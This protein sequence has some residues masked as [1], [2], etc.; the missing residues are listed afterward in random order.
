ME[1]R[2]GW[3][4]CAWRWGSAGFRSDERSRRRWNTS[5]CS[6]STLLMTYSHLLVI[7]AHPSFWTSKQR[8]FAQGFENGWT[9]QVSDCSNLLKVTSL[10]RHVFAKNPLILAT[11]Y[12][13]STRLNPSTIL[14]YFPFNSPLVLRSVKA[15]SGSQ[16]ASDY[17]S[18]PLINDSTSSY[19]DRPTLLENQLHRQQQ[20]CHKHT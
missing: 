19:N 15:R 7:I 18:H 13:R 20:Q 12:I 14:A 6:I 5:L 10:S 11:K 1:G 2:L 9:H 17:P 16:N 8:F 3:W 4:L